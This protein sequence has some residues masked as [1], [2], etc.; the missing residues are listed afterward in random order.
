[1]KKTTILIAAACAGH[2]GFTLIQHFRIK[3]LESEIFSLRETHQRLEDM[4]VKMSSLE[5]FR[6]KV[7]KG[8][9]SVLEQQFSYTKKKIEDVEEE[10]NLLKYKIPAS[11]ERLIPYEELSRSS[12][13][14]DV[15]WIEKLKEETRMRGIESEIRIIRLEQEDR[16][17]ENRLKEIL[18][19]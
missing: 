16:E 12:S 19:R 7:D 10:L 8:W 9:R 13:S 2:F 17:R 4:E 18:S 6:E 15:D 11:K 3:S 5:S 1:M 14:Q